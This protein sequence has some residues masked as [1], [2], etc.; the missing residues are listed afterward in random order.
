LISGGNRQT[1]EKCDH[2]VENNHLHDFGVY[3]KQGV[4]VAVTTIGAKIARNH[5]HHGPRFGVMHG[6]NLNVIE[7]NHLHDLSLE[8][9]DTGAIYSGGRDWIT[10]R[11]SV[12]RHNWIHD[13]Y[14][15]DLHNGKLTT[16]HFSWGIYLDD[17][18][19]GADVIGNIVERCGRG[20]IHVHGARDCWI[21]NNIWVGNRQ[22][23]VDVHGW[24]VSDRYTRSLPAMIEGYEKVAAEP[25]WQTG[26]GLR[27]LGAS[28]VSVVQGSVRCDEYDR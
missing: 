25:A 5:I 20:G 26:T 9:E 8:T 27:V 1:L 24:S 6:G 13:V 7:L 23:Q 14:G 4:G 18:S 19:G 15:M 10:P 11:G 2:V 16:P 22:W 28:C 17:N 12:I 3:F 21:L